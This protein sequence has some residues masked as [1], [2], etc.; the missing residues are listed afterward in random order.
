MPLFSHVPHPHIAARARTGTAPA[1]H[2]RG[3]AARFNDRLAVAITKG[4]GTMWCAYAFTA[5]AL[6]SLPASIATGDLVVIV[7]WV[8]QTFLQ[9]VLLSVI[10]LG[11]N[12]AA[13]SADERD[14][15]TFLDAE[16]VLHTVLEI[17]QHLAAQDNAITTAASIL[18]EHSDLLSGLHNCLDYL[19][20]KTPDN[21]SPAPADTPNGGGPT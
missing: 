3:R 20:R 5:L 12:I 10:L 13:A 6:V 19:A 17:Q 7:S 15:R 1:D 11:G 14:E 18:S 4:V 2:R 8:A 9:L 21:T 16:A